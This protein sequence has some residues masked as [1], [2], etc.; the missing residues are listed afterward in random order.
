MT[1]LVSYNAVLRAEVGLYMCLLIDFNVEN[2]S[3]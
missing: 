2:T 1:K 3:E